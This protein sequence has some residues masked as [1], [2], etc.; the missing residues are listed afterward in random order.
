VPQKVDAKA[1]ENIRYDPL[2]RHIEAVG[3]VIYQRPTS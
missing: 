2:V 1:L 3:V